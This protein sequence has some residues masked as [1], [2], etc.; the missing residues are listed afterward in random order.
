MEVIITFRFVSS[1]DFG[2]HDLLRIMFFQKL[3]FKP[4]L[5]NVIIIP[6]A[7]LHQKTA[8]HISDVLLFKII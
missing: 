1:W 6:A 5:Q 2:S 3:F 4:M 7:R 8:V